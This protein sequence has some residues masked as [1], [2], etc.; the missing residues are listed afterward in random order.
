MQTERKEK[1]EQCNPGNPGDKTRFRLP[2]TL[3][4]ISPF[5]ITLASVDGW[6]GSTNYRHFPAILDRFLA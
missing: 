2:L 5:R 4:T 6:V 3:S 1:Q